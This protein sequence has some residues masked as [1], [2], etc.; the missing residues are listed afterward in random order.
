MNWPRGPFELADEY[1]IDRLVD[2]L[3][4]LYEETG[5]EQYAPHDRLER[6]VDADRV[7]WASGEGFYEHDYEA[8]TFGSVTYERREFVVYVT[9]SR[10]EKRNAMDEGA[11][12]GLRSALERARE[13]D[14]VRVTIL[15][16]ADGAFSA[17]DDIDE[18]LAWESVEEAKA[19]LRG[20]LLPAIEDLRTHPMPTISLV[21]GVATGAGCEMV[22]LSD[23][24]VATAGSRFGQPEGKIGAFPPM[25]ATYGVTNLGKKAVH[26]LAMTGDLVT[27]E[28]A[29]NVGLL[30][31]VVDT[32]QAADVARELA[33]S[34]TASAPG[35]LERTKSTWADLEADL[36]NERFEEALDDLAEQ[37][38]SSEG[39]HGLS[40]FVNGE[41][42]DW[43]R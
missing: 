25:W 28:K 30:N 41:S 5:R 38:V 11:W 7:G 14:G 35:A 21:D 8:T 1:G 32:G 26:E 37:L 13:D 42:P 17:G 29:R 22:L 34:T 10:P 6:M 4:T 40:A 33:R 12:R 2:T 3:R 18:M 19:F 36:V 39:R 43:E 31:Y 15:R 24:A 16:G 27:A 9:V 20:V 23:M